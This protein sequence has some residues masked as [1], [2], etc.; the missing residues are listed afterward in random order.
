MFYVKSCVLVFSFVG[1]EEQKLN[2]NGQTTLNVSLNEGKA[3]NEVVVVGYGSQIKR[4]LVGSVQTLNAEE[5]KDLPVS[6]ITQKLQGRLAGVQINQATGKPGQGMTV[7][8]R[9]QASILANSHPLYVVDGFPIVGDISN[10]NP[11]EIE[12]I[13]VLKDA[14][15]TSLYGSR[16]ANGVVLITTKQGKKGRTEIGLN[17]F[18]G[19]QT[20][21]EKGRVK[22][23]TGQEFAQF[24]KESAEDLG[25]PVPAPFQNHAQY[26]TNND[27][28]GGMLRTAP[29]QSYN[30]TVTSNKDKFN[31]S[32]VAGYLDQD[33]V[34]LNSGFKRFSVRLNANNT[35]SDKVKLGVNIAPNYTTTNTPS[36][37]GAFY[38]TNIGATT[39]GGLLYNALLTWPIFP[40]KMRTAHCL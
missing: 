15:S 26:T 24:R 2:I 8:I 27:W 25:V 20:V 1:Y 16:A 21:P 3:L 17:V 7:R 10:I 28:Y 31:T 39:P 6:Q 5:T 12:T 40:Y 29:M 38:A 19:W 13:S 4:E 22:M 34:M 33:G 14:A 9:G 35:L 37:D 30:L 11:D 32:L 18:K 36:S 23:M